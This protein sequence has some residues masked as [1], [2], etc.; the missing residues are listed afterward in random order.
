M[1]RKSK[2]I[3]KEDLEREYWDNNLSIRGVA[4][5]FKVAKDTINKLMVKYDIPVRNPALCSVESQRKISKNIRS[6]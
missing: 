4:L 5:K 2:I 6:I 1:G 3:P